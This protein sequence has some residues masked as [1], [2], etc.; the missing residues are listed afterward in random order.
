MMVSIETVSIIIAATGVIL[1]AINQILSNRQA[2]Q[3]RQTQLF[4]DLYN[5][6]NTSEVAKQYGNIRFKYRITNYDDYLRVVDYE[7]E[8]LGNID[9]FSDFQNLA[10]LFNGIGVLVKRKLIDIAL[11]EDLLSNRVIWWWEM[12]RPICM[13]AR[14]ATSD[15]EMYDNMEYLYNAMKQY[16]E[17]KTAA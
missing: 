17:T 4:M 15:P 9:A 14:Q 3:Q 7:N 10:Q 1:A 12:Y 8:V 16:Q 2:A 11:V 6:W 5:R 13:G